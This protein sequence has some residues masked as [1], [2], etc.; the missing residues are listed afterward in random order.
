M[1]AHAREQV[2]V[3]G[4]P[5]FGVEFE[6][7][8]LLPSATESRCRWSWQHWATLSTGGGRLGAGRGQMQR[9]GECL[10]AQLHAHKQQWEREH[11]R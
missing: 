10:Y 5:D 9:E 8:D 7:D 2:E 3:G 11:K 4:R 1:S 6:F